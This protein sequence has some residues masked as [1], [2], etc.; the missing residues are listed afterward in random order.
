MADFMKFQNV[1]SLIQKKKGEK[2][3]FRLA[4]NRGN[5]EE[6]EWKFAG[7]SEGLPHVRATVTKEFP[8]GPTPQKTGRSPEMGAD[9][10]RA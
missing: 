2:I 3:F 1:V 5:I 10:G 9:R 7:K 4:E 6:N 8:K